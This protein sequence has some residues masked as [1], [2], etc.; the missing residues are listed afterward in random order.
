MSTEKEMEKATEKATEKEK[1]LET[2]QEQHKFQAEISKVLDIVINSL[3]TDKSIFVRELVSNA[4]DALE[5]M[6]YL[7]LTE[8]EYYDKDRELK[9]NIDLDKDNRKFTITDSGVGMNKTELKKNLGTIARSGAMEYLSKAKSEEDLQ[10]IGQFGVGFYSAFM[11]ADKVVVK[12]RSYAKN[13]SP[14]I[15]ESD[16]RTAYTITQ[17]DDDMPRGTTIELFLKEDCE[18]FT[19]E[20]NIKDIIKKHSSFIS[21]PIFVGEEQLNTI[22]AIWTKSSSEVTQDQYNEFYKF[23]SN[24]FADPKYT[25][26]FKADA[27]IA[28]D[29]LLFIPNINSEKFGMKLNEDSE[30]SLYCKKILIAPEAKNI[31][32]KWMRFVK[33]I[34]DSADL[35]L[36]ISR[37]TLQDSTIITKIRNVLVRKVLSFLDEQARKDKEEYTAFYNEFANFMKEGAVT[38]HKNQEKIVKLLRFQSMKTKEQISV[39]EYIE[40]MPEDQ[41]EVYYITGTSYHALNASPYLEV[42]KKKDIDVLFCYEPADDFVFNHL[43]EYKGKTFKSADDGSLDLGEEKKTEGI[44]DIEALTKWMKDEVLKDKVKDVKISS[45]LTD[46]PAVLVSEGLSQG[47]KRFMESM[48]RVQKGIDI[49]LSGNSDLEINPD[50]SIIKK[51]SSIRATNAELAKE[52]TEQIYD[53][54]VILAGLSTDYRALVQRMNNIMEKAMP[55]E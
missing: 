47:M 6:R 25:I 26:H 46:S 34:V 55:G 19:D 21:F 35:P 17:A 33:G 18:N 24:D 4:S 51:L 36:N 50:H 28:I 27:P 14:Y 39:D 44:A 12:T 54:A 16:G 29:S 11:V 8:K 15:W 53:N 20:A 1:G 9:I 38:D 37:E 43:P 13:A 52:V 23:V 7:S 5:K 31:L 41:K 2:N 42:F 30:V 48:N 10:L 32:P 49:P 40:N 45:R 22:E 3:Y